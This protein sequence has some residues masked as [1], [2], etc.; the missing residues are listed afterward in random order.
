MARPRDQCN[1]AFTAYKLAS[2]D[3]TILFTGMSRS[4][5]IGLGVEYIG[6]REYSL[7][8]DAK[9]IDWIT[10]AR[11]IDINGEYKLM[12][13]EF[14]EE[15]LVETMIFLNIGY[16]MS[17]WDK[18][19]VAVYISSI[20]LFVA[21]LRNDKV[22][23][24]LSPSTTSSRDLEFIRTSNPRSIIAALPRKV[25]S[26]EPDSRSR[27]RSLVEYLSRLKKLRGIL[28]I[29]DYSHDFDELRELVEATK[30]LGKNLG[31]VFIVKS[32]EISPPIDAIDTLLVVKGSELTVETPLREY[33]DSIKKHIRNVRALVASNFIPFIE[34]YGLVHARKH[35]YKIAT[36]YDS[37]RRK[38]ITMQYLRG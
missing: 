38:T 22:I 2:A 36:I 11:S 28:I 30:S 25:C 17:F 35:V 16:S 5:K 23:F 3:A 15:Q 4:R 18:L 6:T 37:I 14:E 1:L 24:A 7:G 9:R 13:K 29:T 10:T 21:T 32:Y 20:A 33:M 19:G 12:V 8:D 27:L 31:L 34:I 26:S